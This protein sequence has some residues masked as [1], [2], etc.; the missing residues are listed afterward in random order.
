L[1]W[2]AKYVVG[3]LRPYTRAALKACLKRLDMYLCD[4]ALLRLNLDY[5]STEKTSTTADSRTMNET[6]KDEVMQVEDAGDALVCLFVLIRPL[7]RMYRC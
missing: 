3:F 7:L 1:P 5:P 4:P 6:K 2:A